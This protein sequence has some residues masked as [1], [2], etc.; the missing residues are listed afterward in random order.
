LYP[1]RQRWLATKRR[2]GLWWSELEPWPAG[3]E[4][5]SGT[6]P[7]SW[8]E[9]STWFPPYLVWTTRRVAGLDVPAINRRQRNSNSTLL[10]PL[11]PSRLGHA[12]ASAAEIRACS[13]PWP[14]GSPLAFCP[15]SNPAHLAR[16]A[17]ISSTTIHDNHVLCGCIA[18]T[19]ILLLH[20]FHILGILRSPQTCSSAQR[21]RYRRRSSSCL[22]SSSS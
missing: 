6:A 19:A 5:T 9:R 2:L 1:C 20:P 12:A 11:A 8:G 22:S 15:A 21:D 13:R 17:P 4:V 16:L 14:D 3:G 18:A 7:R 10:L